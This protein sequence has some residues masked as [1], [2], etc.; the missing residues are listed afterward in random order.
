MVITND[1]NF[2]YFLQKT[3]QTSI[4]FDI[5]EVIHIVKHFKP[6]IMRNYTILSLLVIGIFAFTACNKNNQVA[7]DLEGTWNVD[8]IENSSGNLPQ[9]V[10]FTS[11]KADDENCSGEWVASDGS[12]FAFTYTINDNGKT[13]IWGDSEAG[14]S[15]SSEAFND[16]AKYAGQ[17]QIQ[18]QTKTKFVIT[19]TECNGCGSEI[20]M[21]MSK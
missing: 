13:F 17:W 10:S 5:F 15:G 20:E 21:Q 6:T 3:C 8:K 19:S 9:E 16:M 12:S 4:H 1:K 7:K 18:E 14:T 11:C 2:I